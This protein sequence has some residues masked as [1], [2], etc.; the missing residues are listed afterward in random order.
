MQFILLNNQTSYSLAKDSDI[1]AI[2]FRFKQLNI[3]NELTNFYCEYVYIPKNRKLI[4]KKDIL[5]HY[6]KIDILDFN[7]YNYEQTLTNSEKSQFLYNLNRLIAIS[8]EHEVILNS[9]FFNEDLNILYKSDIN[10]F[11][12]LLSIEE[13]SIDCPSDNQ[14]FEFIERYKDLCRERNEIGYYLDSYITRVYEF[15]L[16]MEKKI[17]EY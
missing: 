13:D 16:S 10:K 8:V 4:L 17:D 14:Y 7:Y 12:K 15:Y 9:L 3:S 5:K 6:L 2:G 1:L 11:W